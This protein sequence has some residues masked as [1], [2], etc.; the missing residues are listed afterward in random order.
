[1]GPDMVRCLGSALLSV[2]LLRPSQKTAHNMRTFESPACGVC[3]LSEASNGVLELMEDSVEV[4]TFRT[5]EELRR[6]AMA[7]LADGARREA[8]ARAGWARV[9]HE[10]YQARARHVLESVV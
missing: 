1:M 7:L 6:M 5:P 8:I 3:T 9:E 10:T 2:N 4:A